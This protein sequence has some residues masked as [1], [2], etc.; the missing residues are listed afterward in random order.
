M[1]SPTYGRVNMRQIAEI[2]FDYI[3][4]RTD[5]AEHN[6]IVIGTDSQNHKDETKSRHCHCC[7]YRWQRW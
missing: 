1:I 4:N 3:R 7:L 6:H 5:V 2:V